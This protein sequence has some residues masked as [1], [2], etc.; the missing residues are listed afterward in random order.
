MD[1]LNAAGP[2]I[3][4][5]AIGNWSDKRVPNRID[6][7][8]YGIKVIDQTKHRPGK[9]GAD[10]RLVIE[11]MEMLHDPELN[12]DIFVI[13]SS[14]HGFMP[15]YHYLQELGKKVVVAGDASLNKRDIKAITDRIIVLDASEQTNKTTQPKKKHQPAKPLVKAKRP[16]RNRS[17][18]SQNNKIVSSVRKSMNGKQRFETRTLVQR[19]L[20]RLQSKRRKRS[21]DN[22]YRAM[23]YFDPTFSVRK[24]GYAR[25]YDLLRSFPD[26]ITVE[27]NDKNDARIR[28]GRDKSLLPKNSSSPRQS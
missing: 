12:I 9:N 25:F 1:T 18:Y 14:D 24:L 21:L 13:M 26:F 28:F 7:E 17:K 10:F 6:W 16:S 22:L 15:L 5:R 2:K 11:A 3:E 27:G 20:S 4:K 23:R 8:R 19:G